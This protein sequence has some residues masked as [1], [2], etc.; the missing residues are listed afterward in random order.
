MNK[1]KL[2]QLSQFGVLSYYT[3]FFWGG[4]FGALQGGRHFQVAIL[5]RVFQI[6]D[7]CAKWQ[8]GEVLGTQKWIWLG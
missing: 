5:S 6:C 1:Y 2:Q 4:L 3:L 8:K 7:Y